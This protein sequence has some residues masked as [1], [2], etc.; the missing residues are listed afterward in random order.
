MRA[1]VIEIVVHGVVWRIEEPM[2]RDGLQATVTK[3]VDSQ[4]LAS[5]RLNLDR[6]SDRRRFGERAATR[7]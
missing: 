2:L 1:D 7:P 5:D 6:E 4:V 3:I